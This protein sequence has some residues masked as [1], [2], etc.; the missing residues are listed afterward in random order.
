MFLDRK[1]MEPTLDTQWASE[2]FRDVWS[3]LDSLDLHPMDGEYSLYVSCGT[4][5]V[6]LLRFSRSNL[7][8]RYTGKLP[9]QRRL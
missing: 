7:P 6:S 1:A 8:H 9:R 5:Y 2:K 4:H 3:Q